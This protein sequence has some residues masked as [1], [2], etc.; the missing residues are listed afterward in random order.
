MKCPCKKCKD[1]PYTI[2]ERLE[3]LLIKLEEKLTKEYELLT[4]NSGN[5]CEEENERVGGDKNS[6]HLIGEGAD[7]KATGMTLIELAR[8]CVEIGFDRIGIYPNHIHV[9]VI[10]PKPSH[11][12][13]IK[14]YGGKYIYSR[15]ITNLDEFLKYVKLI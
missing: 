10:I 3:D 13:Y 7:I 8:V 2:N 5:R 4:I 6:P 1:K 14:K 11:F 15:N 12:W 9:D